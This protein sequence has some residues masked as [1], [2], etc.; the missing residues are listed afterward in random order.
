MASLRN[1]PSFKFLI[2]RCFPRSFNTFSFTKNVYIGHFY[3][4]HNWSLKM[5]VE[6]CGYDD[7]MSDNMIFM[8]RCYRDDDVYHVNENLIYEQKWVVPSDYEYIMKYV[9]EQ[10][11]QF[12]KKVH[13]INQCSHCGK[14]IYSDISFEDKCLSCGIQ[15]LYNLEN[16]EHICSIC[17][18]SV[19]YGHYK[20]CKNNHLMHTFCFIKYNIETNKD[21]CPFRCGSIIE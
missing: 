2:E 18:D 8:F 20:K 1:H 10:L 11:K 17:H 13:E 7:E 9:D 5:E 3:N 12:M 21:I 14:Y 15:N 16:S 6:E 4:R 19:G